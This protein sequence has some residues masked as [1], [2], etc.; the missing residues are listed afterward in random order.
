MYLPT[1]TYTHSLYLLNIRYTQTQ[2]MLWLRQKL[3]HKDSLCHTVQKIYR[4]GRNKIQFLQAPVLTTSSPLGIPCSKEISFDTDFF[5]FSEK[6][7]NIGASTALWFFFFKCFQIYAV[8]NVNR[9][10]P[11]SFRNTW[12]GTK[13]CTYI[14]PYN[15]LTLVAASLI[16]QEF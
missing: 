13:H 1:T 7:S 16:F 2:Y 10:C 14:R 6:S 4:K 3:S 8:L 5:F 12:L 11:I 15:H 9:S